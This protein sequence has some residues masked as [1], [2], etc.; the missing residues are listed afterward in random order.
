[1]VR[2]R[3]IRSQS[4]FED[5]YLPFDSGAFRYRIQ[6]TARTWGVDIDSLLK[7]HLETLRLSLSK[8]QI[9]LNRF[10]NAIASAI[11]VFLFL[12]AL[13]CSYV[14][15]LGFNQS[16]QRGA[17]LSIKNS[18]DISSIISRLD[19]IIHRFSSPEGLLFFV[20]ILGFLILA[21]VVSIWS[22]TKIRRALYSHPPSALL[23]TEKARELHNQK[24]LSLRNSWHGV[25]WAGLASL[26]LGL[27]S[28]FIFWYLFSRS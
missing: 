26:A 13:A 19:Y 5:D 18:E 9:D 27:V 21:A 8:I 15:F 4:S 24:K 2:R 20:S 25:V 14:F 10:S 6:H 23:L 22:T 3:Y 1:M 12:A 7:G 28:N 17:N 11:G 16:I